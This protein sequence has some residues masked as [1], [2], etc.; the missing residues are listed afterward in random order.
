VNESIHARQAALG[1]RGLLAGAAVLGP[2]AAAT[3]FTRTRGSGSS[4]GMARPV[5]GTLADYA[6]EANALGRPGAMVA[7]LYY[8]TAFPRTDLH[9][10]SH[11]V[12]ISPALGLGSH[13]A[14]ARYSDD[15]TLLMGDLVVTESELQGFCDVL[16]RYAITPTAIHKHLLAQTPEVWWMHVCATDRDG[17]RLAKGMRA[18]FD[19]THTPPPP[20]PAAASG[21]GT[22]DLD[23][24]ALD[25]TL[26]GQGSVHDGIY[27]C[28]FRRRETVT[29]DG[30]ILPPGL[31]SISAFNFQPLSHGKAA[32]NGDFAMTAAEVPGTLARLRHG[33]INLVSLHNHALTDEPR[34]FF[35]HL[36]A[37]D[38]AL[39]IATALRPAIDHTNVTPVLH[40]ASS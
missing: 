27:T 28:A 40:P 16:Q 5:P 33:G 13:V 2:L 9:V 3:G 20:P 19:R 23:T 21:P 26:G 12:R 29:D 18:A 22:V 34:L 1:R 39:K 14:F 11:G 35:T 38:D 36:W 17:A 30:R 6:P 25:R 8:H 24:C 37:V 10:V 32:V 31:G 4:A 15:R 7:G